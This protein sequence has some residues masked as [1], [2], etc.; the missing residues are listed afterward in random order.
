LT[1][2]GAEGRQYR[3]LKRKMVLEIFRAIIHMADLG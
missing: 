3:L 2:W 1:A